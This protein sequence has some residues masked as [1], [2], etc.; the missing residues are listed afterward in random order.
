MKRAPKNIKL[1]V[2]FTFIILIPFAA[3]FP[4]D[5]RAAEPGPSEVVKGFQATLLQ[6]M[7]DAEKLNV[8]QRFERLGPNVKK[9][10]HIP[11]MVQIA[12]GDHWSQ[13]TNSE[14]LDLVN[15]FRRMSTMT[16]ATLFDGYSGETFKVAN[17]RPGPQKTTLVATKL[18]KS[19]KSTVD[20]TYVTRPFKG[21]WRII[22]V[23]VDNG[24]S[25]LMV[26]RS[27]YRQTLKRDGIPGLIKLLNGK[28]DELASN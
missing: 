22:D 7:K 12:S 20:I 15:A 11:L 14:R 2:L 1:L 27:E 6:V 19:D 24:I 5:S 28:A 4:V 21:S 23:I 10:F 3:G 8:Q 16:L 26:R 13:A 18:I 25:E 17:E 9:S